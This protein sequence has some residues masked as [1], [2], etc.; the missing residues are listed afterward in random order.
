[1]SAIYIY[2]YNKTNNKDKHNS[3]EFNKNNNKQKY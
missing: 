1:M 3:T 2:I